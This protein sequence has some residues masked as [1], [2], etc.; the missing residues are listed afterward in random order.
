MSKSFVLLLFGLV[1]VVGC[2]SGGSSVVPP[3]TP[4]GFMSTGSMSTAR[5]IH[6]ATLLGN[7]KVLVAGGQVDVTHLLAS[8]EIYD[9]V[10]GSF[11]QTGS[12][13]AGRSHQTATLLKDGKVFI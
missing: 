10:N 9:P 1:F 12:M 11:T 13:Q 8:A 7:G 5:L 4:T 2:S 3:V 6:T